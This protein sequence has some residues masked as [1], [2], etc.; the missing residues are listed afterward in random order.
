MTIEIIYQYGITK[1]PNGF[2][3]GT[4]RDGIPWAINI[5]PAKTLIGRGPYFI[6]FS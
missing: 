5:I 6:N 2:M 4:G 3:C 1:L